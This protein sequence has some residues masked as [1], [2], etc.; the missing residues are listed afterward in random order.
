MTAVAPSQVFSKSSFFAT[1]SWEVKMGENERRQV[2]SPGQGASNDTSLMKIGGQ[3]AKKRG[4]LQEIGLKFE[5]FDPC[6]EHPRARSHA[7]RAWPPI[8]GA[9]WAD[10]CP[11]HHFNGLADWQIG[12]TDAS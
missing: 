11:H 9:A 12:R 5:N 4:W 3:T 7:P 6:G 1:T 8:M 2:D 10:M